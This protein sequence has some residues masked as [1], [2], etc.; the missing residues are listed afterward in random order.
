MANFGMVGLDWQEPHQLGQDA[1]VSFRQGQRKDES[2][3]PQCPPP[4]VR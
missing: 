2:S 1:E 4:D 3:R